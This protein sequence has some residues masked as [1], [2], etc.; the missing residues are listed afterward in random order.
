MRV[1][2]GAR[3]SFVYSGAAAADVEETDEPTEASVQG[4]GFRAPS[5]VPDNANPTVAA[6]GYAGNGQL[7]VTAAALNLTTGATRTVDIPQP[8]QLPARMRRP[9]RPPIKA[10]SELERRYYGQMRK[11]LSHLPREEQLRILVSLGPA[12]AWRLPPGH[13]SRQ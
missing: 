13:A 11:S 12:H 7:G 5:R 1:C 9:F 4:S 6:F 3:H 2:A 10:G 8:V